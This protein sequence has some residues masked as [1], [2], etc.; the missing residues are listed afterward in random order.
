MNKEEQFLMIVQCGVLAYVKD[1]DHEVAPDIAMDLMRKAIDAATRLP[2]KFSAEKAAK[3]F[4]ESIEPNGEP[5][6]PK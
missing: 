1:M 6:L 2:A 3:E 4:I 5:A